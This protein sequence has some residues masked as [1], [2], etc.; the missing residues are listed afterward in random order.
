MASLQN[1][2][3]PPQARLNA[4]ECVHFP[5]EPDAIPREINHPIR[6]MRIC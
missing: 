5:Q 2:R 4:V 1:G 3:F 6:P